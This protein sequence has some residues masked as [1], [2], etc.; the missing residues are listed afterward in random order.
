MAALSKAGMVRER[1]LVKSLS[2]ISISIHCTQ[3]I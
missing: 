1:W 2:N 3:A